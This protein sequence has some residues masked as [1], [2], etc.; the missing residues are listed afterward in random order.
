M[1]R[2]GE[3]E[4]VWQQHIAQRAFNVI[5]NAFKASSALLPQLPLAH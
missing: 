2:M 4:E 5:E 1:K 3:K